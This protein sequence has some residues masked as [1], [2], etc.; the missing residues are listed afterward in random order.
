[1]IL[2]QYGYSD[3]RYPIAAIAAIAACA[4]KLPYQNMLIFDAHLDLGM[5]ALSWNGKP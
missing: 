4:R 5:N 1:M 2:Q 3:G